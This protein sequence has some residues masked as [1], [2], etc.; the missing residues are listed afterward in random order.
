MRSYFP[1]WLIAKCFHCYLP[2]D[3]G[4]VPFRVSFRPVSSPTLL[5]VVPTLMFHRAG[6]ER[7]FPF[8][9]FVRFSSEYVRFWFMRSRRH[10]QS[11][12]TTWV[13]TSRHRGVHLQISSVFTLHSRRRSGARPT[14]QFLEF[15]FFGCWKEVS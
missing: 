10:R 13:S 1:A 8:G 7:Q 2:S 3:I 6:F 15:P 12:T 14:P 11:D 9:Q 5:S 4:L